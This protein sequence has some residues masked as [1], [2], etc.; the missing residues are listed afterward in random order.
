MFSFPNTPIASD[1]VTR[2][3]R[4]DMT[5]THDPSQDTKFLTFVGIFFHCELNRTV[6]IPDTTRVKYPTTREKCKKRPF[7]EIIKINFIIRGCVNHSRQMFRM[8]SSIFIFE[9]IMAKAYYTVC[10]ST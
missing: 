4:C 10:F 1:L 3:C 6:I 7:G 2:G 8:T 9:G 5:L